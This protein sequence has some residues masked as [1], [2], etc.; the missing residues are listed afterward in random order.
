MPVEENAQST[1]RLLCQLPSTEAGETAVQGGVVQQRLGLAP[2]DI[3]EAV[4]LL[5]QRGL[6]RIYKLVGTGVFNFYTVSPTVAGRAAV[7]P[8]LERDAQRLARLPG[9]QRPDPTT[10][11]VSL[12]G[13]R[14]RDLTGFSVARTNWVVEFLKRSGYVSTTSAA[15]MAPYT[16]RDA[17]LTLTGRS[18][19]NR[20]AVQ[21]HDRPSASIALPR[22]SSA[23]ERK[24]KVV[25]NDSLR[26]QACLDVESAMIALASMD[27]TALERDLVVTLISYQLQRAVDSLR[28]ET[29]D[30]AALV[31]ARD[32]ID[33]AVRQIRR[34]QPVFARNQKD[35]IA[36]VVQ[37][38]V[39]S[40][41]QAFAA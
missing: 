23:V 25:P 9:F 16:F 19:V 40:I 39:T 7:D 31:R 14:I 29:N 21:L 10:G 37:S 35:A 32:E 28:L 4:A 5:V 36:K 27:G 11:N 22:A 1:L 3:N 38:A 18:Y 41:G 24:L 34:A 26:E 17:T 6:V 20:L 8:S 15:A 12:T 30:A 2:E 33:A 13:Q